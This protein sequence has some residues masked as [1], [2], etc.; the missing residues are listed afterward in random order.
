MPKVNV[1]SNIHKEVSARERVLLCYKKTLVSKLTHSPKL[2]AYSKQLLLRRKKCKKWKHLRDTAKAPT[3]K[4]LTGF[5]T[6][7]RCSL[8]ILHVWC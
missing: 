3:H 5:L 8:V 4:A 7:F 1:Y 2:G 6:E